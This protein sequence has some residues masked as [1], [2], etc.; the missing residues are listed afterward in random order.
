MPK[1][2][3]VISNKLPG[4]RCKL[5]AAYAE[6][7]SRCFGLSMEIDYHDIKEPHGEGYPSLMI[8]DEH[9]LPSDGVILSPEDICAAF[10]KEGISLQAAPGFQAK[11][12]EIHE[13]ILQGG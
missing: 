11:L 8:G 5:Y 7:A 3:K 13:S 4:G 1:F 9:L 2:I 10:E 12:E 6:E